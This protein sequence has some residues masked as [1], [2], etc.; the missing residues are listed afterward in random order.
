M[1]GGGARA[2]LAATGGE[3][4]DLL[5]GGDRSRPGAREGTS[6]AEVLA[7]DADHPRVLVGRVG[8]DEL[9]RL[10]VGL[11]AERGEARDAD[12]VLGSE[13]AQLEGEVAALRDDPDRPRR[14]RVRADV[15]LCRGV[16]DAEAVRAD[17]DGPGRS[18]AL[19]D[20]SLA[21]LAGVVDLARAP[22]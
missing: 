20:G 22:P 21:R 4:D 19:D 17:H 6:V 9:R 14:E 2:R 10:D 16:V 7:V 5:P 11:V 15:E 1:R 18:D 13:E 12:A 3:Q 8:L